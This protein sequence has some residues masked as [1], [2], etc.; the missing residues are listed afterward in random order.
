MF[1]MSATEEG[2]RVLGS[3][4]ERED[5]ED[6]KKRLRKEVMSRD[7]IKYV[8]YACP[9]HVTRAYLMSS[10]VLRQTKVQPMHQPI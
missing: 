9:V 6:F 1:Q 4:R 3:G 2:G 8:S 7:G 10:L 5:S